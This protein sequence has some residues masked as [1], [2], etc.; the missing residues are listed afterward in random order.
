MTKV[1]RDASNPAGAFSQVRLNAL[2]VTLRG[3][4][5]IAVIRRGSI[6]ASGTTRT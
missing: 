3:A 4:R 6:A 5:C 2:P 1:L